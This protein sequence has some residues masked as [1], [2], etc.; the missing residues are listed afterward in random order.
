MVSES[1]HINIEQHR[2]LIS[3]IVTNLASLIA[4]AGNQCLFTRLTRYWPVVL[5]CV[6][7]SAFFL[8]AVSGQA[9]PPITVEEIV[10]LGEKILITTVCGE[11]NQSLFTKV[12]L[13]AL[14]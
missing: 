14:Y 3:N 8:L 4:K 6:P 13:L 5:M 1:I 11:S 7:S 2:Y 10:A 9:I 12:F